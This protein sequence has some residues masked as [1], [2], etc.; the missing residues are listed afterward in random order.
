MRYLLSLGSFSGRDTCFSMGLEVECPG[1]VGGDG[2]SGRWGAQVVRVVQVEHHLKDI[3]FVLK[4]NVKFF[5]FILY[6]I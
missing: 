2:F 5:T 1:L 3:F 4:G 6:S